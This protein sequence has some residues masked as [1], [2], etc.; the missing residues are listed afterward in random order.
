MISHKKRIGIERAKRPEQRE[1]SNMKIFLLAALASLLS[2][3]TL[4]APGPFLKGTE[5]DP[6]GTDV[7]GAD[8]ATENGR[9]GRVLQDDPSYQVTVDPTSWCAG[10][11]R[12]IKARFVIIVKDPTGLVP[13]KGTQVSLL[14]VAQDGSTRSY[15]GE[16]TTT[17]RGVAKIPLNNISLK[18]AGQS[19][20]CSIAIPNPD[21][22]FAQQV[23]C[24]FTA[25]TCP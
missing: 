14:L 24:T 13:V 12:K 8:E 15:S 5:A 7:V 25:A 22:P 11:R 16:G 1:P 23:P 9:D 19:L 2:V 18:D 21:L 10:N 6:V 4:A 17:R 20:W 3:T